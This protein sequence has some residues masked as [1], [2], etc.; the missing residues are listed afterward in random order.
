MT[1]DK[2]K[3]KAAADK[4]FADMA[5]AMTAG[6]CHVGAVTGLFRTMAGKGPLLHADVVRES[7]LQPRYVEEW[8]NGMTCAGYLEYDPEGRTF[9]L[10]DEHAYFLASEGTDH[11]V[12]GLFAMAPALLK[13]APE[14]ATAFVHGGGV[15]F[16]S[17]GAQGV[18]ALDLINRGQYEHRFA[19]YW[20]QAMPEVVRRLAAGGRALDVGCGAGRV[21]IALAAAFPKAGIVGVDA[22]ALSIGRAQAAAVAAGVDA[23]THFHALTTGELAR[24][25]GF[26][27][28][29]A[30]DCLHDFAQPVATLAEIRALLA[31]G[32]TLF[33]MEPKVADRLEDNRNAMATMF[34]GFSVFHCMTQSL[35]EGGPGLGTCMGPAR[36]EALVREAGFTTFER[37]PIKSQSYLFYAARA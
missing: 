22:D 30:C 33:I 37:L 34:Y 13:V 28:I 31:P 11:Y 25:D 20:M 6:L 24:G 36:T 29:S 5:G 23:R 16:S 32:G 26:D 7:G 2:D 18:E 4:V 35:A 19:S 12:G 9:T 10:P 17:Y 8:L 21:C 27:F 15:P 1:I 3:L 14:V